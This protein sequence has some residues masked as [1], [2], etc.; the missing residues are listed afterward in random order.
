M[1]IHLTFQIKH[2]HLLFR[3]FC[4]QNVRILKRQIESHRHQSHTHSADKPGRIHRLQ[5]GYTYFDHKSCTNRLFLL[6][7]NLV[8]VAK[9]QP[10][11]AQ[12]IKCRADI[13]YTGMNTIR[14]IPFFSNRIMNRKKH[15]S[16]FPR[17]QI[18]L[19]HQIKPPR[20]SSLL[21]HQDRNILVEKID[22]KYHRSDKKAMK[23]I[24]QNS[25]HCVQMIHC[26]NGYR[27]K[28]KMNQ[29]R[30]QK[31]RKCLM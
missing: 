14:I 15:C 11:T 1:G 17:S 3:Q 12:K 27:I 20:F 24:I 6:S 19:C 30:N 21:F 5:Q 31:N 26:I 16:Q 7:V 18:N 9:Q 8:P 13:A 25:R 2:G 28:Y 22:N 29:Y 10:Y 4:T 23:N